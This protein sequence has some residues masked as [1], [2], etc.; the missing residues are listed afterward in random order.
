MFV[1][2]SKKEKSKNCHDKS[3]LKTFISQYLLKHPATDNMYIIRPFVLRPVQ[4]KT[5]T[6]V[7]T[8]LNSSETTRRRN[9]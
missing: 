9:E 4:R 6:E 2:Q 5:K 1:D 3:Q 7:S 8:E